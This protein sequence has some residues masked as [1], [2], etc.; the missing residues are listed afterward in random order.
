MTVGLMQDQE[1]DTINFN[2]FKYNNIYFPDENYYNTNEF[3][4]V[5][6]ELFDSKKNIVTRTQQ[7]HT[8]LAI[9]APNCTN[10]E[11][12][13]MLHA[14]SEKRLRFV[15]AESKLKAYINGTMTYQ[16]SIRKNE[17]LGALKTI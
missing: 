8:D 12:A 5:W 1:Y 16:E 6:M 17:S 4:K 10:K 9:Y 13:R 3:P 15:K 14:E 11:L 7:D 2:L